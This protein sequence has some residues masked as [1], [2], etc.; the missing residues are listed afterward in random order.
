MTD[1]QYGNGVVCCCKI[2]GLTKEVKVMDGNVNIVFP[3]MVSM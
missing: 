2:D 3:V 1:R